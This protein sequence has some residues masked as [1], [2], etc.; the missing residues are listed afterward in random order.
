[1][2]CRIRIWSLGFGVVASGP[3]V[4]D[5]VQVPSHVV[6]SKGTARTSPWLL[7]KKKDLEVRFGN[8]PK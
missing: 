5:N 2:E 1:M 6:G 3:G 7:F 8:F 4:P